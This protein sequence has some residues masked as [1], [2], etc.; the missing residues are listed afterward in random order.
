M[1]I[2]PPGGFVPTSNCANPA[3]NER[4]LDRNFQ[5]CGACRAVPYCSAKCAKI[6]WARHK[7]SCELATAV[8]KNMCRDE[9]IEAGS[10]SQA[11][12]NFA[13][14]HPGGFWGLSIIASLQRDAPWGPGPA[15]FTVTLEL[16]TEEKLAVE[17]LPG[18]VLEEL[19][20]L[21]TNEKQRLSED[22]CRDILSRV[23]VELGFFME[24]PDK[25]SEN[26]VV[27]GARVR[28]PCDVDLLRTEAF[29]M[30]KTADL[31]VD[32]GPGLATCIIDLSKYAESRK[33]PDCTFQTA[34][35]HPSAADHRIGCG[36]E[37]YT[38][39]FDP[40]RLLSGELPATI[41]KSSPP[42]A[43][44]SAASRRRVMDRR[45]NCD[46]CNAA[47]S[48]RTEAEWWDHQPT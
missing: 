23:D 5:T 2:P 28:Y 42:T 32:V 30:L 37:Q 10:C 3:C 14:A 31:Q 19:K 16:A 13:A 45:W 17:V 18:H 27:G 47:H 48:I 20:D 7:H 25:R 34:V 40:S 35:N 44:A 9:M 4:E 36:N 22:R 39:E 24:V 46:I 41:I 1:R 26:R 43:K 21:D 15:V 29:D 6:D 12:S 11:A 8:H 33:P 38:L